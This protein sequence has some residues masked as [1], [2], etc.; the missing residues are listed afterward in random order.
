MSFSNKV[1]DKFSKRDFSLRRVIQTLQKHEE[2]F[3]WNIEGFE[4]RKLSA[5]SL[6]AEEERAENLETKK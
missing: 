5:I 4:T 2:N 6:F 3:F 1:D